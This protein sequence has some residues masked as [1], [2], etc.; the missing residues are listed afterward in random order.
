M[1][2]LRFI[3]N[4]RM[5]PTTIIGPGLRVP[6]GATGSGTHPRTVIGSYFTLYPNVT[7]GSRGDGYPTMGNHV[8]VGTRARVLGGVHIGDFTEVCAG[9]VAIKDSAPYSRLVGVPA[10]PVSETGVSS[11]WGDRPIQ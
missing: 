4:N 8:T 7:I 2:F 1:M 10:R 11:P 3:M 6:Y 5:S 9:S